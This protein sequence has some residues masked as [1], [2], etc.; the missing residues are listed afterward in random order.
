MED[1]WTEKIA[2]FTFRSSFIVPLIPEADSFQS[3]PQS[4]ER[5]KDDSLASPTTSEPTGLK[6]GFFK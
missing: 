3:K 6:R 2:G 4:E 5:A 1:P